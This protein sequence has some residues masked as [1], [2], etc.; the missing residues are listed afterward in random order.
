MPYQH[1]KVFGCRAFVHIPKDERSKFDVQTIENIKKA[2]KSRAPEDVLINLDP[3]PPPTQED[4]EGDAQ[5]DL[6]DEEPGSVGCERGSV[7]RKGKRFIW[8]NL[9]D[10][11]TKKKKSFVCRLKKSL[12]GL[13]QAPLQWYQKFESFMVDNRYK[14][15]SSDSC[16]FILKFVYGNFIIPLLCV[17]DMLIIGRNT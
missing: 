7:R 14:K 17:D 3:L 8:S 11:R 13:K 5:N 12:Y 16:V 1:L 6:D 2:G 10:F 9:K 4:Q 15:T